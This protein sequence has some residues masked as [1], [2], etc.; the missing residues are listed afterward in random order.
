MTRLLRK[1]RDQEMLLARDAELGPWLAAVAA[2]LIA[3][4]AEVVLSGGHLLF[5]FG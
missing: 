4:I 1:V 2:L 5:P 3:L